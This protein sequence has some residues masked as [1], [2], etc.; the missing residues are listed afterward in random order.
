MELSRDIQIFFLISGDT[1]LLTLCSCYTSWGVKGEST[2]LPPMWPGSNPGVDAICGL[3]F[4]FV[5][6]SP[7]PMLRDWFYLGYSAFSLSLKTNKKSSK[8]QFYLER[9][10]TFLRVLINS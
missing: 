8:F 6:G 7:D 3:N 1:S 9:T 10:E 5:V 2:R 4:M